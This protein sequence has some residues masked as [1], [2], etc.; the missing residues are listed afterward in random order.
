MRRSGDALALANMTKE[1][2]SLQ[3]RYRCALLDSVSTIAFL[4]VLSGATM[5][6]LSAIALSLL[7]STAVFAQTSP[8]PSQSPPS[9]AAPPPGAPL[10]AERPRLSDDQ[11]NK[12]RADRD[13]CRNEVKP[14]T[15]P[16]GERRG[17]M[18]RCIEAKNPDLR[19]LFARGEARRAEM[20]KL[21]DDCRDELRGKNV[22]GA[23]RRQAMQA[24]V[25]AK[26]PE[27][28]KVFS[29]VDQ[30]KAKNLQPG[31]ERRDFMRSCIRA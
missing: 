2:S 18:R 23:E 11:R 4:R 26:K 31:P 25:V 30:A 15:L 9:Q 5:L 22:R 8:P 7:L 27:M 29:C 13:A 3:P 10:G 24:C 28:A 14:Q 19:P 12:L 6:R 17:A 21:R 20:R 1:S 16:R